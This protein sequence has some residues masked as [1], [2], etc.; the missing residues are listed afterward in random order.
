MMLRY[1]AIS[2]IY[3]FVGS[4]TSGGVLIDI[5]AAYSCRVHDKRHVLLYNAFLIFCRRLTGKTP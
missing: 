5:G 1:N 3:Q 4:K 2:L